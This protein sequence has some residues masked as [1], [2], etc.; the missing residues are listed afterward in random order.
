VLAELARDYTLVVVGSRGHGALTDAAIGSHAIA[1]AGSLPCPLLV[2]RPGAERRRRGGPVV[3]ALAGD[4][5]DGPVLDLA[6][7]EAAARGVALVA[8]HSRAHRYLG[9][10]RLVLA[11]V[12]PQAL[13]A[14]EDV[15]ADEIGPWARRHPEVEVRLTVGHGRPEAV[16]LDAARGASLVVVGTRGRG[17]RSGLLLGSVAQGVL[18]RAH[19][20]VAVVPGR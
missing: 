9:A 3:V 14:S 13:G 17:A 16:V 19:C 7:A 15:V 2:V 20:P 5:A 8:V 1:L 6:F 10:G 11:A 4:G 18:H 12:A